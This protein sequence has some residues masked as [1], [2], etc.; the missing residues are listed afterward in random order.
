MKRLDWVEVKLTGVDQQGAALQLQF[1]FKPTACEHALIEF[2]LQDV[3]Q[4]HGTHCYC[5]VCVERESQA[6]AH[7]T[8]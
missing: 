6:T 3:S 1:A 5:P 2:K 8:P 4:E 7:A